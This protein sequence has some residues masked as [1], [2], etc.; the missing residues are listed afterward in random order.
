MLVISACFQGP[1]IA[2]EGDAAGQ[3]DAKTRRIE[4]LERKN[5]RLESRVDALERTGSARKG[6]SGG[7]GAA[8]SDADE[9]AVAEGPGGEE[10]SQ[11]MGMTARYRDVLATFQLFGDV[12]FRY[13]NPEP[14]D[15]A[16]T[17]FTLGSV[18][19]F[20]SAQIG[21]RFHVLS[22][23]NIVPSG[24]V[25]RFDQER[26]SGT[27]SFSDWLYAKLGVD[28]SA[29]SRWNRLYHHG[30][31]LETSIDRPFL[32]KFEGDDGILPLHNTGL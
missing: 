26:L 3:P 7:D 21:Q 11:A 23:T 1:M 14:P 24:D 8:D 17:Y 15:R 5:R 32:A 18:D 31:W 2:D 19:I 10:S 30:R 6:G 29:I 20:V 12:D 27:W 4:E 22:E 25:I 9:A 28:H 16:N 13:Q